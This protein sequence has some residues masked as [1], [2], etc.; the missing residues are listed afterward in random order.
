MSE[1]RSQK[2]AN[3][4]L[5]GGSRGRQG[6][7]TSS[8]TQCVERYDS[9]FELLRMRMLDDC[10]EV[11]TWTKKHGIQIPYVIDDKQ[12]MYVPDFC[13]QLCDGSTRF[14]EIKGY[15]EERKRCAKHDALVEYC[16]KHGHAM[17]YLDFEELE[18]LAKSMF[19]QTIA[20]LRRKEF[21]K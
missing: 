5:H 4:E 20:S 7:Y 18:R 17:M 19:G 9:F 21:Q 13:V 1:T 12:R 10:A 6:T 11:V 15:E 8:K 3:S 14:E 16:T 2:I